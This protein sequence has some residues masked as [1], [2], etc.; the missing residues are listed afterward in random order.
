MTDHQDYLPGELPAPHSSTHQID[1][2]DQISIQAI[3]DFQVILTPYIP[4]GNPHVLDLTDTDVD[5]KGFF[6]G[7]TDGRYGYFVPFYNGAYSGK[8]ARVDLSDFATVAV[9]DLTLTDADLKGFYGGFTDGRYGYFVP[10]YNGAYFG[11]IAR[12][13][14]SDFATVAVLDLTLTDPDLKGFMGGFTDGRYGYFVPYYNGAYFGKIPR[15]LL[16]HHP[17][18][19]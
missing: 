2:D 17:S 16:R 6:G 5:L 14:L 13:D 9:L 8:I 10:H 1:G 12:V 11:K 19:I 18:S 7:F 3:H 4:I 15:T